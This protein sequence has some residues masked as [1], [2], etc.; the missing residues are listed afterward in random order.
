MG[1]FAPSQN[2]LVCVKLCSSRLTIGN[3]GNIGPKDIEPSFSSDVAM[4]VHLDRMSN[5]EHSIAKSMSCFGEC[6]LIYWRISPFNVGNDGV[7]AL[8]GRHLELGLNQ[9]SLR[10]DH[11]A[12]R[13]ST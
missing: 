6:W 8:I 1:A 11:L 13:Y 5:L 12:C 2:I 7:F 3:G 10:H 4:L 9:L